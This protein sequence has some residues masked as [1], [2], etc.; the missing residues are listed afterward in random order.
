MASYNRMTIIGNLGGD[1]E[2]KTLPSGSVV[3]DFS[4]AVNDK[5]KNASGALVDHT[6]WYRVSCF[7]KLGE[8]AATYLKKGQRVYIEGPLVART[9]TGNDGQAR[10][11]LDIKARVMQMLGGPRIEAATESEDTTEAAQDAAESAEAPAPVNA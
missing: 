1:P 2:L 10:I 5:H 11:S 9:Y 3:A 8:I 4:V 6:Q 7:D